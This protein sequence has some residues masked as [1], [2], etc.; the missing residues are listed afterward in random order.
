MEQVIDLQ[1]IMGYANNSPYRNNP[2]L[3]IKTPEG[4]ITMENTDMDLLGIDNLG[5]KK[6]MKAKS[7]NPYK[8]EGNIVREIPIRLNPY[9]A[10]GL[11]NNQILGYLFDDEDDDIQQ[12]PIIHEE[13]EDKQPALLKNEKLI[14]QRE[15]DDLAMEQANMLWENPYDSDDRDMDFEDDLN[16]YSTYSE[17]ISS[18]KWGNKNIGEYGA[19]IVSEISS[20]LGYMPSFTSIYRDKN[21][22]DKLVKQGVGV[23]NSYHLTGNAVDMKISDWNNLPDE[24]KMY[25]R[26]NYDVIYHNNHYHIE[27]K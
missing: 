5:N 4:V 9:Q 14:R 12:S 10:G 20:A 13:D 7:K 11:T 6:L 27:P 21:Q 3:D 1:S 22:Q 16:S 18:G 26:A 2:Y 17:S 8:F 23:K 19:K 24:K 25:F 15:A